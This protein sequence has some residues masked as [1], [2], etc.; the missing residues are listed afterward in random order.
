ML[1]LA[2]GHCLLGVFA[3]RN[4]TDE[5]GKQPPTVD[6][7]VGEDDLAWELAPVAMQVDRL[8]AATVD[9]PDARLEFDT[10]IPLHATRAKAADAADSA[11]RRHG[12]AY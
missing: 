12:L 11:A 6:K 10:R 7:H 4:D 8:V 5:T 2:R 9:L 3:Q 1:A